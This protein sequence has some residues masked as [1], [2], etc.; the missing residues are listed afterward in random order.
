[1]HPSGGLYARPPTVVRKLG[2]C[3]SPAPSRAPV[4]HEA[5][6]CGAARAGAVVGGRVPAAAGPG[7]RARPS[8][9]PRTGY[10]APPPR[11]RVGPVPQRLRGSGPY[12]GQR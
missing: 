10:P 8:P 7:G 2:T 3:L 12:P 4:Y 5:G 9:V 1:M 6:G 11:N